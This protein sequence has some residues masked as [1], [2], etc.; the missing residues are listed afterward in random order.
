MLKK[1]LA[2]LAGKFL[3]IG[4]I[5]DEIIFGI[6]AHLLG[7]SAVNLQMA[8]FTM[9]GDEKFGLAQGVDDLQFLLTGVSGDMESLT[10]F[11]DHLSACAI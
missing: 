1:I 7:Q 11:V 5:V 6:H 3:N 2:A 10:L 4:D 9:D 8:L